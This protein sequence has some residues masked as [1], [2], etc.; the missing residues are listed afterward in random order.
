MF[1][2]PQNKNNKFPYLSFSDV[3]KDATKEAIKIPKEE[4]LKHGPYPIIDQGKT[5]ISGYSDTVE[6][7]FDKTPFIIFGDHTRIFKYVEKP[8]FLGADGVKLLKVHND[9]YRTFFV[10]TF[11]KLSY[12]PNEG[13]SRH[14]KWLKNLYIQKPPL[15]LQE[16]YI[17]FAKQIDKSKFICLYLCYF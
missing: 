2:D 8:C 10:Y 3:I 4:Y 13:Y 9:K 5:Y 17:T 12:I 7:L 6:G 16:E 15:Y 1:G 11:L 14:F